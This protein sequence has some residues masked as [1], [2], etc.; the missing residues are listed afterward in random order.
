[1]RSEPCDTAPKAMPASTA[2]VNTAGRTAAQPRS[3]AITARSPHAA[4]TVWAADRA[5]VKKTHAARRARGVG[6][7]QADEGRAAAEQ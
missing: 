6:S 3:M 7:Q 1:M 5:R 2:A 4:H